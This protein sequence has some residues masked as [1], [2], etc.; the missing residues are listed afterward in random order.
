MDEEEIEAWY[1]EQKDSLTE[2]YRLKVNSVKDKENLKKKYS[3]ILAISKPDMKRFLAR[4]LT[5]ILKNSFLV[6]G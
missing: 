4:H 3:K 1:D 6:T 5:P 2:K